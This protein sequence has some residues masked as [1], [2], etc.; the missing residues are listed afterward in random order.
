MTYNNSTLKLNVMDVE[1]IL[2]AKN[3]GTYRTNVL[4]KWSIGPTPVMNYDGDVGPALP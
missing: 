4:T 1:M 2:R 3:T